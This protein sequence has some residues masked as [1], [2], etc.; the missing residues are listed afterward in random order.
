[1]V[2]QNKCIKVEVAYL[3]PQKQVVLAVELPEGSTIEA[4]IQYSGIL[5][6][7]PEIDL[8]KQ[9]VGIFSK[10][11]GLSEQVVD[12]DRIEIYRPLTIDPKEARR[13]KAKR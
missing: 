4:A 8:I 3:T 11:R 6:E 7:F 2:L 1:M 9:P 12:G 5:G 10:I 13:K